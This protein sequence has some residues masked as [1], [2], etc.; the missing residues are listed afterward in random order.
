MSL[1]GN[2]IVRTTTMVYRSLRRVDGFDQGMAEIVIAA[3]KEPRVHR[4]I[5][6]TRLCDGRQRQLLRAHYRERYIE[7]SGKRRQPFQSNASVVAHFE[8]S[9]FCRSY[10]RTP[11]QRTPFQGGETLLTPTLA[12][13][14]ADSMLFHG[15]EVV[16]RLRFTA[17]SQEMK[18]K[19]QVTVLALTTFNALALHG[20][21]ALADERGSQE[22]QI[23]G[24]EIFGD[25]L[26]ETPISRATP[27]L[28]SYLWR[29]L[30]L[31]F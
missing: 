30:Y 3:E 27:R 11:R 9:H 7:G 21:P 1:C 10:Y 13:R 25:R 31:W 22:V 4:S 23:Y 5:W 24:G 17:T 16:S 8:G 29:S 18:M 19:R 15:P 26:T 2:D 12:F 6:P 20:A 14:L 28:N